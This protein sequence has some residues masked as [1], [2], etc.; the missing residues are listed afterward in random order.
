VGVNIHTEG[1]SKDVELHE[2]NGESA[3]KQ[4]EEL[5]RVRRQ[6]HSR[7]VM[8]T[9]SDLEKATREGKNVMPCL[10][11][12]CK[13]YATVGEMTAVFRNIFGEFGEPALF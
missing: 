10:V 7:E 3:E 11:A 5:N 2:Y 9:L 6:R 12:C 4:I 13:A 8:A 1:E